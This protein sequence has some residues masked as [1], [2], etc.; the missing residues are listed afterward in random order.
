MH[1]LFA[2]PSHMHKYQASPALVL[3][4]QLLDVVLLLL[5]VH[6]MQRMAKTHHLVQGL[7]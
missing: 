2:M 7:A 6:G 5:F 1:M 3:L 4:L